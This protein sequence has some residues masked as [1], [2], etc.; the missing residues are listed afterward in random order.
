MLHQ[1]K[2]KLS[3]VTNP[4]QVKIED[5]PVRKVSYK[6]RTSQGRCIFTISNKAVVCIANTFKCPID[7]QQL[8]KYSLPE[9]EE[10]TIFYTV[11]SYE[12]GYGRLILNELLQLLQTTR[13]V[14]LSPKTEMAKNFHTRNGAK[15][16][17]DNKDSYN[18][19][20]FK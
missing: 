10:F 9:A 16:I 11:W 12:K 8:E 13:Y 20:Y 19:E 14:T 18:F 3:K 5:D 6:F 2:F 7:M 15:L 4:S 1:K 17:A